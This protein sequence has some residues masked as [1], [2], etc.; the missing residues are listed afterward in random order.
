MSEKT[1]ILF[2]HAKS[3]WESDARSD[4]D[5]PLSGRGFKSAPKMGQWLAAQSRQPQAILASPALRAQQTAELAAA[6]L[7][8][9]SSKIDWRQSMYMSSAQTLLKIARKEFKTFDTVM[10]VA[11]NPGMEMLLEQL[12]PNAEPQADGKLMTTAN[13]AVIRLADASANR[14]ELLILKRPNEL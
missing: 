9:D 7:G 3:S 10:L 5:R 14:G 13:V 6:E 4:F 11:H 2:R 12:C 1:L 8:F